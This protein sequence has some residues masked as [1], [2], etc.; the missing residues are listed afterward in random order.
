MAARAFAYFVARD[1]IL[2]LQAMPF[3]LIADEG[4]LTAA[5]PQLAGLP[6]LSEQL[7]LLPRLAS[8]VI[9]IAIIGML[10]AA[11]ITKSLAA[12]SGQLLEPNQELLPKA[13]LQP[14]LKPS[15]T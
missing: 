10:E 7:R 2:G 15:T 8:T 13:K 14:W 12:K 5:V 1:H 3:R 9:A 4:A 6:A 11:A